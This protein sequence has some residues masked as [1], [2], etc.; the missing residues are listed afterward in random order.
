MFLRLCYRREPL[1]ISRKPV[2]LVH[3]ANAQE[4]GSGEKK[5]QPW[6]ETFGVILTAILGTLCAT[7]ISRS[8]KIHW[9]WGY[10]FPLALIALLLAA[11]YI[12][13]RSFMPVLACIAGGRTRF[14]II[15]LAVTMGSSTLLRRLQR[16]LERVIVLLLMVAVV[17]WSSVLPFLVPALIADDLSNLQTKLDLNNVCLQTTNYTCGPAAAVT[18]LRYLGLPAQEGEIAV[19][20]HTSPIAGT[21]PWCLYKALDNR[22]AGDGLECQFRHFNSVAQLP[23]KTVTLAIVRDA[24]LLDHCVAVLEVTDKIVTVADPVFGKQYMSHKKFEQIWRFYGIV[25]SRTAIQSI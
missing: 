4:G 20:S 9:A 24:F 7:A 11:T 2:L 22:Y 19:L 12:S 8:K 15:C 18:A 21:L 23:D 1:T 16:R 6:L 3:A 13:A 10:F 14:V 25:L 5:M 17:L